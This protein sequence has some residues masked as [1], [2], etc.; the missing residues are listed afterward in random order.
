MEGPFWRNYFTDD[1]HLRYLVEA[2]IFRYII[3]AVTPRDWHS[4]A[5]SHIT[6][7]NVSRFFCGCG[8]SENA[9][10]GNLH[11]GDGIGRVKALLEAP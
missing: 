1:S 7:R 8:G 5:V 10:Q 4:W 3:C 2:M 11:L 9:D 6:A